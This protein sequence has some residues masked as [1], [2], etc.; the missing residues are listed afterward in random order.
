[1]NTVV[2]ILNYSVFIH[3]KVL[4]LINNRTKAF[5]SI[6]KISFVSDSCDINFKSLLR[7]MLYLQSQRMDFKNLN[8]VWKLKR[9]CISCMELIFKFLSQ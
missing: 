5:C 9:F 8:G 2:D 7:Q 6:F 4:S 3:K 1:M